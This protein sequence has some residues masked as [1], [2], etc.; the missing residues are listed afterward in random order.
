LGIIIITRIFTIPSRYERH[1]HFLSFTILA[2]FI[3][4]GIRFAIWAIRILELKPKMTLKIRNILH[5]RFFIKEFPW[6]L[7]ALLFTGLFAVAMVAVKPEYGFRIDTAMTV[8]KDNKVEVTEAN[9]KNIESLLGKSIEGM[10]EQQVQIEAEKQ[11]VIN[12]AVH[13]RQRILYKIFRALF[14]LGLCFYPIYC[15][16]RFILWTAKER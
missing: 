4:G 7:G 6:I 12:R 10:P 9:K 15:L 8:N 16:I 11:F 5:S 1:D 2:L 3:Y 14:L 13:N